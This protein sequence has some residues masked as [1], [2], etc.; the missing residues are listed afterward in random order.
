M[1]ALNFFLKRLKNET[2]KYNNALKKTLAK[3]NDSC[4]LLPY[5][6]MRIGLIKEAHTFG[7]V[8]P[9]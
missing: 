3:A 7:D 6:L 4:L 2:K 1:E 5:P 9:D 8:I